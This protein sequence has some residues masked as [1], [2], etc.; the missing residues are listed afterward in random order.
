V[1]AP[2]RR[3]ARERR[4]NAARLR[5]ARRVLGIV[6]MEPPGDGHIDGLQ[7][8]EAEEPVNSVCVEPGGV[9]VAAKPGERAVVLLVLR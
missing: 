9:E 7:A 3:G 8:P 2:R 4:G 1:Q 6:S 5:L